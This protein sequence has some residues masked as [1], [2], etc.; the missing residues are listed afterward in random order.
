MPSTRAPR[1]SRAPTVEHPQPE[2]GASGFQPRLAGV[3]ALA[4]ASGRPAPLL[5]LTPLLD[6]P[7]ELDPPLLE[8][9]PE[10][11]PPPP[12]LPPELV[13]PLPPELDPELEPLLLPELEPLLLPE[14]E[15]ELLPVPICARS[16]PSGVPQP[17]GPSY[18]GPAVQS[19]LGLQEPLLPDVTS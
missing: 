12:L 3:S 17:V 18:P 13:L 6:P 15:P 9:T 16:V 10:L 11:E 19:R 14:L 8:L 7:L 5:E 1:S 4:P 2:A